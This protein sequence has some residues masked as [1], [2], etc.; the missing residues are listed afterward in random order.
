MKVV[1][2]DS[3]QSSYEI[4]YAAH[5]VDCEQEVTPLLSG[6]RLILL[7]NFVWVGP[8]KPPTLDGI[9]ICEEKLSGLLKQMIDD[10]QK[11]VFGWALEKNYNFTQTDMSILEGEDKVVASA[12]KNANEQLKENH[13]FTFYFVEMKREINE[14]GIMDTRFSQSEWFNGTLLLLLST[15]S[16]EFGNK[17][18]IV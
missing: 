11:D 16:M 14:Y 17:F 18:H 13:C 12:L 5:H 8:F 7:Y 2:F 6:Y 4:T 3:E 10:D 15:W 1:K 9:E